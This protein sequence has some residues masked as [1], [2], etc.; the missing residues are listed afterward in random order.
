MIRM[1]TMKTAS[2][3]RKAAEAGTAIR[4]ILSNS[5]PVEAVF[6][7]LLLAEVVEVICGDTGTCDELFPDGGVLVFPGDGGDVVAGGGV[8]VG[9]GGDVVAGGGVVV[10]GGGGVMMVSC[11]HAELLVWNLTSAR[12]NQSLALIKLNCRISTLWV[13]SPCM[14]YLTRCSQDL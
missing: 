3:R 10:G 13:V 7:V 4:M 5:S 6:S 2:R 1:A 11:G 9:G 12:C 14:Q 8:V